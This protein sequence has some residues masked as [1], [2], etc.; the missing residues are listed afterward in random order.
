MLVM[1]FFMICVYEKGFV[2]QSTIHLY[3]SFISCFKA[4]IMLKS[5]IELY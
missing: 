4:E 5:F 1:M 2:K 3:F